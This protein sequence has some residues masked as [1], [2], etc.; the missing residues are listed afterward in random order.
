[1]IAETINPDVHVL[2][3]ERLHS[4]STIFINGPDVLLVEGMASRQDAENLRDYIEMELKKRVRFILCTHYFSD[5]LAA[6]KLFPEARIIAHQHY[7]HTFALEEYR[8]VE[9]AAFFVEPG[10]LISDEMV[11]RWGRQTLRI[12]HNPSHTM[13]N[14]NLDVPECDLI[15]ASD[16]VVGNIVYLHYSSMGVMER[17]LK[18]LQ[19]AGRKH[20]LTGHLGVRSPEA[21]EHAL[22]YLERLREKT[23]AA[24]SPPDGQAA[25]LT[26]ELKSCLPDGVAGSEFEEFFH[27]RN[28]EALVKRNLLLH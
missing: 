20:L 6:L 10:I 14:L 11:I 12:F 19:R 7:S 18:R 25:F 3:G 2:V 23:L 8:S 26:T 21:I 15:M 9:E 13:S 5:H 1:M 24:Q 27:R 4:N 22:F 17:A 28:L 16:A